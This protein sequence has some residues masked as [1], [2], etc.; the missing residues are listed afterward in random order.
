[1]SK[2]KIG[3][4]VIKAD[5][6]GHGT[7]IEVMPARRGRQLY[8]VSWG[9]TITDELEVNLL[10]D[11]DISDPFERCMSGIFG[12]YS[13]YSK[14]NTT[15]KIRSSNNSTISSLKASKTLFRAYQFKPLLKFLNSPNR[16][17]LVA[18]EVGLGKTIEAGHIMLELKARRELHHVLIVCPKSLQRK[19]KDELAFKF[20]LQFKI[21]D[22]QKELLTDMQE[23][24]VAVHAIVN[25]EKIRLKKQ[26][27]S[28]KTDKGKKGK[29]DMPKNIV[30]FLSEND[31]HFSLVLCDEAH[32]MRNRETQTY[33]GAE[34]IMSQADAAVFLTATPVMI[35]TENLYNLLHLLDNTRYYNYQIFDNRLQENRPFVE[36]LTD[37]NHHVA[38]PV[39]AKNLN[40]AEILTRFF[41]DEVE[42]FSRQTTVGK[43]FADDAMYQEIMQMLKGEDNSKNRARLQYLISSMSM[44]NNIFSR[45]RKREVTTDMSQAERKP[46][47]RKVDLTKQERIEFDTVIEEYIDDNSYTDYWGE[48]VLT[49]G[50]ALGLVQKKRQ[51]A[52][53]VYAYL[54]SEDS[55][56]KGIDEYAEYPDAKFEELLKIIDEVFK[57]GTKKIVIFALFRKTLKYLQIRFKNRGFGT[58]MIHGMVENRIDVLDEFKNNPNAHILL[59]SEVGSEGLD[60]QFCNS[61]VNYDLPWNPM[62]VE[63]R[64]GRID[65]FGQKSPTVNIY[66][67][68]VAD[69]IQE[70]IYIRLLD[71]IGIFRGTIG[72]MEAILDAPLERG[73]S[74]T[75]Q[76]VYNKLEK[77]LYT[78]R[79]TDEEKRRK[80][81][82]IELAVANEKESIKHLEEG[83]DN[84]LTNDAYF[85]EEINRIQ[86]NNAYVTEIEL[87]NYLESAIRQ[88]LS[89]CTLAK[90][91][92]AVY[93]L[94]LPL[95]HPRILQNFLTQYQP[96]GE[97]NATMFRQFKREIEDKQSLRMTF[98]QQ[99]AYDNNKLM[100]MNIY[101]PIIQACLSYF[102]KHDDES[103]TSF[104]YA[105]TNDDLL[106]AGSAF[107]LIVYQMSVT[108]KVLGFPKHTE[109]LLPLLYSINDREIVKNEDM[110]DRVFSRSQTDGKE[111]N[112]TNS[113]I[114]T[115]MLQDMRY[116][117]AEEI[118]EVK[119]K[120]LSEIKLQVE[121]DR[122]RNEKQTKEYYASIIDNQQRFIRSWESDIEMYYNVDEKRVRQLQGVIRLAKDR[123]QRYEK[124]KEDRLLQ[125][126]EA[127]QIEIS[128]S[129]V[130]L[131]LINI[132]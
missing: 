122:H 69:S 131:N 117:F 116:D 113:D 66:N 87:R 68:I 51:V 45:T 111:H 11:C 86:D 85:K 99:M 82:E 67:I 29:D 10:P 61:M 50:G 21:Y 42:I 20:G 100:F 73:G 34:I 54:N 46:H 60:M 96:G 5:F 107:Y 56:D 70:D 17:L 2:Y 12:S 124:E 72:D 44:M 1:M 120:R 125:I 115:E 88:E 18:D 90:V 123:I 102:R 16:R 93:E 26:K 25:Y 104:C 63:Q 64:I 75:I 128:E 19:W 130:S 118:N 27:D 92:N 41:S 97:E 30:D 58:L 8:K 39:I 101:H 14:K 127:S 119:A 7:I 105:L 98:N 95:S 77:E 81:A 79:L 84:A 55:L 24:R 83:L 71:R 94:Q 52:S 15:F 22:S 80:I 53:S 129:V 62:V 126:R 43:A 65:R 110:I 112:A 36:A 74:V 31:F 109:T 57:H 114:D 103:Q 89:T 35:S 3:N 78:S 13:E 33:K 106:K 121:S 59:S 40:E 76:D 6:E 38:F 132:I 28:D 37:L 49:Q 23:H 91:E 9:N 32:K 47:M 108:R 48:E 4:K